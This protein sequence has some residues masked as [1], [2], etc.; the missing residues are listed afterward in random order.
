M[1]GGRSY[2]RGLKLEKLVA[3]LFRSKGYN[4]KH[5][6]KLTGRSGVKHQIDVYAE[7]RAPLHTSRIIVE[8]KSYD[9]PVDKDIVMKLVHEVDDLGVDRGILVTTSYFTP[10]AVSTAEGYNVD[11]WDGVKLKK[12]LEEIAVEEI[13]APPNVFH[14]KPVISAERSVEIVKRSVRAFFGKKGEIKAHTLVFIPFYEVDVEA[15]IRE[16]KGVF[17]KKVEERIVTATILLDSIT[18]TLCRYVP[19]SGCTPLYTVPELSEEE[20]RAFQTLMTRGAVTV[21]AMA[22]LLSCSTAKARK[23]LQGLVAKGAV[24]MRRSRRYTFYQLR[25]KIPEPS[26]LQPISLSLEMEKGEPESGVLIKPALGLADVERMVELL[27]KGRVKE[28][29]TVYYPYYA[30]K[31]AEDG[32]MHVR[33]VDMVAGRIDERISRLLTSVCPELPF[34]EKGKI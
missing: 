18:R 29:R 5:N 20:E 7:Y 30:C 33:A 12:L 13:S 8:C 4:V 19:Q 11:L 27:W 3:E 25:A 2:E 26:S 23:L 28:Y 10:D 32:K 1:S 24:E 16:L 6:V 34:P 21:A 31:V 9:R 17:R 15:R 14:V 22:S